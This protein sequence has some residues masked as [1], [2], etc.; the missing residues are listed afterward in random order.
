MSKCGIWCGVRRWRY[1]PSLVSLAVAK[2]RPGLNGGRGSACGWQVDGAALGKGGAGAGEVW[3]SRVKSICSAM[4]P[5]L[6]FPS[7]IF[8]HL[9]WTTHT[10]SGDTPVPPSPSPWQLQICFLGL[11]ICPF[12]IFPIIGNYIYIYI[13]ILC[14]PLWTKS[15]CRR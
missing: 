3:T 11:C 10:C 13:Y 12:G 2:E 7:R 8:H 9:K 15:S 5:S 1:R 4:Q 14:S 6:S